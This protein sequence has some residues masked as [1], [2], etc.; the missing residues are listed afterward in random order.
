M[1]DCM[2]T[3][4]RPGSLNADDSCVGESCARLVNNDAGKEGICTIDCTEGFGCPGGAYCLRSS[5]IGGIATWYCSW[6]CTADRDCQNGFECAA[7]NPDEP[8][9]KHCAVRPPE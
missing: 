4:S 7:I 9:D 3:G 5:G 6:P 2:A 1:Q 8:A